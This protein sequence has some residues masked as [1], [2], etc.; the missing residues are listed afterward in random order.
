MEQSIT[1]YET[2]KKIKNII[3][4]SDTHIRISKQKSIYDN[5]RYNEYIKVFDNLINSITNLNNLSETIIL[6]TGDIFH[7]KNKTDSNGISL[8]NYF[9]Y[10]FSSL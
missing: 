5:S 10:F 7:D 3:H 1:S 6:I 8:F 4:I 2:N 9:S